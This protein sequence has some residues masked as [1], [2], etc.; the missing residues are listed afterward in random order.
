[1]VYE[2]EFGFGGGAGEKGGGE[3]G[4]IKTLRFALAA[5]ADSAITQSR[6]D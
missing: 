2:G 4:E 1:M 3:G 5:T 6:A